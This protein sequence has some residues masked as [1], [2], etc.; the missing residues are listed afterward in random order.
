MTKL[1][2]DELM[3]EII[4]FS[5]DSM[6]VVVL[7]GENGVGK[8]TLLAKLSKNLLS[9]RTNDSIIAI[10]NTPHDKF[11]EDDKR[12]QYLGQRDGI[13][14]ASKAIKE[15]LNAPG[16]HISGKVRKLSDMLIR[17]GY[18]K[19]VGLALDG[20]DPIQTTSR[21]GTRA[22][23]ESLI[24]KIASTVQDR[25]NGTSTPVIWLNLDD[26]NESKTGASF[27][28]SILGNENELIELGALKA[29]KVLLYKTAVGCNKQ[30]DLNTAS[31]GEISYLATM[32]WASSKVKENSVLLIEEPENSLHPK[33][34][35]RYIETLHSLFGYEAPLVVIATHSP[36]LLSG[37]DPAGVDV[38]PYKIE[39]DGS[40]LRISNIY[41][42][43]EGVSWSAFGVLPS[44]NQYLSGFLIELINQYCKD[45]ITFEQAEKSII[46]LAKAC[47]DEDQIL[48]VET[49]G[50][51][52]K[53]A[54]DEK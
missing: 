44:N 28:P 37:Q 52:L 47:V 22:E 46:Q 7:I 23:L 16:N 4:S 15:L 11:P 48:V 24:R 38:I 42:G 6:K 25:W 39:E 3:S 49:F 41:D 5:K 14:Y 9:S 13:L 2:S 32:A 18:E 34:Q 35:I 51:V 31:S 30:I 53:R 54:K 8:S 12:L 10:S 21:T 20:F 27:A 26:H 50:N 19:W 17:L 1:T 45:I 43:L 40:A 36:L 33:W 29:I